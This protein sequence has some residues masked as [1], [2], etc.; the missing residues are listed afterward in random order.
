MFHYQ[1][2]GVI[3]KAKFFLIPVFLIFLVQSWAGEV[4]MTIAPPSLNINSIV[5]DQLKTDLKAINPL[6]T[7][8]VVDNYITALEAD[9]NSSVETSMTGLETQTNS[10]LSGFNNPTKLT[11][12]FSNANAYTMHSGTMFGYQNYRLFSISGGLLVG[13]QAPSLKINPSYISELTEDISKEKD[14]HV[15]SGMGASANVAL[16]AFFLKKGLYLGLKYFPS[17]KLSYEGSSFEFGSMGI[18]AN[19]KLI[20]NLGLL[21]LFKWRG[22]SLGSGFYRQ[23]T[24]IKLDVEL[25]SESVDAN[26]NAVDYGEVMTGTANSTLD[27]IIEDGLGIDGTEQMVLTPTVDFNMD[28]NTYMIPLEASTAVSLFFGM[29]NVGAGAGVDL[30]FGSFESSLSAN[31]K[32]GADSTQGAFNGSLEMQPVDA[33]ITGSIDG[34]PALMRPRLMV[35]AGIGFGP[36]K[37]DIPVIWYL[38]S[39]ATIGLTLGVVL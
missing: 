27:S 9:L 28:I 31:G 15:G 18:S 3:M 2:K 35:S 25:P 23:S 1:R 4:K 26:L 29:L 32:A 39:G 21:G 6:L 19:Y 24:N 20:D 30:V 10:S 5:K 7:A 8:A 17:Q 33:N 36:A 13:L 11:E 38:S 37:I 34:G 14:V 12:G 22:L 16:N